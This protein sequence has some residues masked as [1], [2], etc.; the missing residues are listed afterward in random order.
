MEFRRIDMKGARP[1]PLDLSQASTISKAEALAFLNEPNNTGALSFIVV[2]A[3]GD[4]GLAPSSGVAAEVVYRLLF[5]IFEAKSVT[6]LEARLSGARSLRGMINF[7]FRETSGIFPDQRLD[8]L[9]HAGDR[10]VV[11]YVA[12]NEHWWLV[13]QGPRRLDGPGNATSFPMVFFQSRSYAPEETAG[14]IIIA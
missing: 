4:M 10:G 1:L 13:V 8:T 14:L 6:Q 7:V 11:L 3:A 12:I 9:V 2:K 5:W